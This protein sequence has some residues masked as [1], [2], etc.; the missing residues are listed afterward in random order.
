MRK[1]ASSLCAPGPNLEIQILVMTN[2][3]N[4]QRSVLG[5]QNITGSNCCCMTRG[6]W[7]TAV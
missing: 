2:G 4:L 6:N 5:G 7:S 1:L 3:D